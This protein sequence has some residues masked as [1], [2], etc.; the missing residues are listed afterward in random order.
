MEQFYTTQ[1]QRENIHRPGTVWNK[2]ATVDTL[3]D[4]END[5]SNNA[6]G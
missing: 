6:A 3:P 2:G 5:F 1:E 4:F